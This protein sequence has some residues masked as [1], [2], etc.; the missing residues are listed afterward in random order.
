MLTSSWQIWVGGF[1]RWKS[2]NQ[3]GAAVG[4]ALIQSFR[5]VEACGDMQFARNQHCRKPA[6]Q[7]KI[8]TSV[9]FH[10]KKK[11]WRYRIVFFVSS[12]WHQR[13]KDFFQRANDQWFRYKKSKERLLFF[14]W[15]FTEI[16]HQ[17]TWPFVWPEVW[18]W[19][20]WWVPLP[21]STSMPVTQVSWISPIRQSS[22]NRSPFHEFVLAECLLSRYGCCLFVYALSMF[23]HLDILISDM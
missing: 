8:F 20:P 17:K 15:N 10:L 14:L 18:L 12:K 11:P 1:R 7:T 21:Q 16:L 9:V 5:G 22:G 13:N 2:T 3:Q 6:S 19:S 23:V 4:I